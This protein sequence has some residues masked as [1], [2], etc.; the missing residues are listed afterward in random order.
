MPNNNYDSALESRLENTASW[1]FKEDLFVEWRQSKDSV[2]RLIGKS[3][4]GKTILCASIIKSIV[5]SNNTARTYFFFDSRDAQTSLQSYDG[6]LCSITYQLCVHLDTLPAILVTA[7]RNCGSGATVPSRDDLQEICSFAV[8]HFPEAFIII[9]ALDEC[10]EI[11]Q[12]AAWL[13]KLLTVGGGGLHVLITSRDKPDITDHLSSQQQQVIYLDDF[14]N[15]DIQLYIDS[16][17]TES[18]RLMLWSKE[19]QTSIRKSLLA[20]A[21]GMFRWVAMQLSALNKCNNSDEV[22]MQLESLP[23]DLNQ[24]YQQFFAKLHPGY[25]DIVLTIMQWL[26]FSKVPLSMDQICE[27]VAIIKVGEGQHPKYHPGKKWN[28]LSVTEV[29]ADLVTVMDGNIKL[30]HFTVKEYLVTVQAKFS[31]EDASC[32]IAESCLGYLL[33]FTAHGSLNYVNIHNFQLAGYAAKYWVQHARDAEQR[34]SGMMNKLIGDLF[35][36]D[37]AT[38]VTWIQ[39][40]DPENPWSRAD[41]ERRPGGSP[42]HVASFLGLF[43]QVQRMIENGADVNAQG[44]NGNALQAASY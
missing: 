30:A 15:A 32:L 21:G 20:G 1:I 22:T 35:Q 11:G 6:I 31:E 10:N 13:K 38:F 9:D 33:Q 42:L 8:Q 17:M 7:Y 27:A 5:Q 34:K 2:L 16:K 37:G 18:T 3:G 41:F 39:L 24:S 44:E 40:W 28:R 25:H 43:C 12:V 23:P 19:I 4:S 36:P 29:C 26:A 14:T